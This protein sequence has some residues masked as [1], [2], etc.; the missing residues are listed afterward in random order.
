VSGVSG[1][2]SFYRI[3]RPLTGLAGFLVVSSKPFAG[4][5]DFLITEG[6][7]LSLAYRVLE[8]ILDARLV[9]LLHV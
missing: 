8:F 5:T 7:D 2:L 4:L 6:V 3:S 9:D 1:F